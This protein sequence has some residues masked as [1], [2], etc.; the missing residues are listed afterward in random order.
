M[1]HLSAAQMLHLLQARFL[2]RSVH[3]PGRGFR[4]VGT[5]S[6]RGRDTAYSVRSDVRQ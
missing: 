1:K 4:L 3:A 6:S 5:A 2:V